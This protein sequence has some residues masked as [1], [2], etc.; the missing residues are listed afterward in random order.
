MKK[1][2]LFK[3]AP[4]IATTIT[5]VPVVSVS[6]TTEKS[7][8]AANIVLGSVKVKCG[9]VDCKFECYDNG[10]AKLVD[11]D[12]DDG[13]IMVPGNVTYN[14]FKYIV[15]SIGKLSSRSSVDGIK[16]KNA[17]NLRRIEAEAFRGW[18]FDG[19]HLDLD[20]TNT[21]LEFVGKQAFRDCIY[22]Q[23]T[24]A[25]KK[26]HYKAK[27]LVQN[28]RFPKTIRTIS[29]YAFSTEGTHDPHNICVGRIDFL[30]DKEEDIKKITF[31]KKWT[32]K[33]V[34]TDDITEQSI[35]LETIANVPYG[36]ADIYKSLENFI[37]V[38]KQKELTWHSIDYINERSLGYWEARTEMNIK[39]GDVRCQFDC[40]S[41][42]TA[43]LMECANDHGIMDRPATIQD[44]NKTYKVTDIQ[45]LHTSN[46]INKI[47]GLTFKNATNLKYIWQWS[48]YDFDLI[49]KDVDL[50]FSNNKEL[51]II[52]SG[53]FS[54][55]TDD[56]D[57]EL[58]KN[59]GYMKFPESL[60][61]LG[62]RVFTID[63]PVVSWHQLWIK[64]VYFTQSDPEKISQMSFGCE[65]GTRAGKKREKDK[66]TFHVPSEAALEAYLAQK[67]F[68]NYGA[69]VLVD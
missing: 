44:N 50:D 32:T 28:I 68:N 11:A 48:F 38:D 43:T 41:D 23:R 18:K 52:G 46:D 9:D 56:D 67:N 53:A 55:I 49:G 13:I 17:Y 7:E 6:C 54:Y 14:N 61:Y 29:D 42:G 60:K 34:F 33:R 58:A 66:S 39:C 12:N 21:Q 15:T 5:A 47:D 16:F 36:C 2:K 37:Y 45:S 65:W 3:I 35:D 62:Q 30:S 63:V 69:T 19:C 1:S 4:L 24:A 22:F 8:K 27:Y 10:E 20:F 59:D 25:E 40:Y 57:G 64:N 31:G 26:N 51:E